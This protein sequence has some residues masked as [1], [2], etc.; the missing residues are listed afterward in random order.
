MS[1]TGFNIE[2]LRK[3]SPEELSRIYSIPEYLGK[4]FR[5]ALNPDYFFI[6]TDD[7]LNLEEMAEKTGL[8]KRT[9][10]TY[11][12]ALIR[13]RLET[14][15][16]YVRTS[17]ESDKILSFIKDNSS[18][19]E[20]IIKGTG[21]TREQIW[22]LMSILKRKNKVRNVII[23]IGRSNLKSAFHSDQLLNYIDSE[24]LGKTIAC[25]PGEEKLLGEKVTEYLA[26]E[27]P[28]HVRKSLTRK[29]RGILPKEAFDVVYE[30]MREHAVK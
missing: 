30:Y 7:D 12:R 24:L 18:T 5:A 27:L 14:K 10:N 4:D 26:E 20:E 6:I 23:E 25:L 17:P 1:K 8:N 28:P 16:K 9:I 13:A 11:R 21:K 3:K 2:E 22:N 19:Y 29:F 15:K